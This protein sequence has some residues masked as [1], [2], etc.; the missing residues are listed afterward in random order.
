MREKDTTGRITVLCGVSGSGKT[1][2]REACFPNVPH[3][4]IADEYKRMPTIS[5]ITATYNVAAN[6][7]EL[8][9]AREPHVVIEGYF[10]PHSPSRDMLRDVLA[11]GGQ[12]MRRIEFILLW[13]LQDTCEARIRRQYFAGE[14]DTEDRDTRIDM[15][16]RTWRDFTGRPEA[17]RYDTEAVYDAQGM[18]HEHFGAIC[19]C[20]NCGK[21]RQTSNQCRC[22]Y[23]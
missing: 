11:R 12:D 19:K 23:P 15:M 1:H 2:Y 7:L 18:Y 20:E 16:K 22:G 17:L 9:A 8:L 4:D 6:A 10:L 5:Y 3:V 14:I 13:T 21:P